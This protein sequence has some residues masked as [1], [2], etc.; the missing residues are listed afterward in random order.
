M[1]VYAAVL[2][3]TLVA[4][5]TMVLRL[6]IQYVD[7]L[8]VVRLLLTLDVDVDNLRLLGVIQLVVVPLSMLVVGV[9]NLVFLL[10]LAIALELL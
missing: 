3:S 9:E 8:V 6:V 7:A 5:V 2:T 10:V 4:A 1:T